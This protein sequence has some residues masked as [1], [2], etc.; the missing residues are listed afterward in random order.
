MKIAEW[1]ENKGSYESGVHLY[2]AHPKA[3][4]NLLSVFLRKETIANYVKLKYE[5]KKLPDTLVIN[6]TKIEVSTELPTTKKET[7]TKQRDAFQG[8]HIKDLPIALHPMYIQQ[9][10]DFQT[11][12][13]LKLQLNAVLPK[14]EKKALEL[15]I[16]IETLFDNIATAWEVFDYYKNHKVVIDLSVPTFKDLSPTQLI[17]RRN[18]KRSSITKAEKRLELYRKNKTVLSTQHALKL[19]DRR[20]A[21]TEQIVLKHKT[22]LTQLNKL[23]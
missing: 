6:S 12:C 20:I 10:A 4:K 14:Q 23:I 22:E 17:Q 18:S 19:I 11:A 8:L 15:C 3:N 16:K 1:L 9:K 2:M 7:P 5:L 13:S 21:K